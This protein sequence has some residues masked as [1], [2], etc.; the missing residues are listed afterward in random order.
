MSF[1]LMRWTSAQMEFRKEDR[2]GNSEISQN[3]QN[4]ASFDKIEGFKNLKL[5][6]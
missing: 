3:I 1:F 2:D 6:K 5:E 4:L